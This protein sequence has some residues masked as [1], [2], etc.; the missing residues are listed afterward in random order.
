LVDQGGIN[1]FDKVSNFWYIM[2][3]IRTKMAQ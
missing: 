1:R 3:K 2:Y